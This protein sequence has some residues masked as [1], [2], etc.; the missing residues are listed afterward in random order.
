MKFWAELRRRHVIRIVLAYLIGAWLLIQVAVSIEAPLGLP[1]WFDTFVIVVTAIGFPIVAVLAWAFDITA[2]GVKRTPPATSEPAAPRAP[3]EPTPAAP[4]PP[5][6]SDAP[7]IAVLPF[8]DMSPEHDQEYFADGL[9][10][11]LLNVLAQIKALRVA[12]RTSSFYFKG[13][14][15]SLRTIADALGVSHVLEGSVRKAGEQ[16]R[17]T[18][19]LINAED[20]YHL[21]SETY[22]RTLD[23]IFTVQEE[24][25]RAVADALGVTLGLQEVARAPGGTGDVEAYDLYLRA[26]GLVRRAGPA[27]IER[28]EALIRDALKLDPDFALAWAT[29]AYVLYSTE[30]YI[31]SEA[32]R[33]LRGMDEA[34]ERALAIA[35]ELW[36]THWVR[37]LQLCKHQEWLKAEPAL[38]R[39]RELAPASEALPDTWY[40]AFLLYVGQAAGSLPVWEAA[41]RKDPLDV[42]TTSHG[43]HLALTCVGRPADAEA[44]YQRTR[45]VVGNRETS[46]F[47]WL[48]TLIARGD[49][50]SQ[51]KAQLRRAMV[52]EVVP[53][54]VLAELLDLWEQPAE[55]R[56][57]L[58]ATLDDPAYQDNLRQTKLGAFAGVIGDV[59]STFIA[60]RRA[61][62]D[63]QAT[64]LQVIWHPAFRDVRRDARFKELLR[65]VGLVD[66]WRETGNW[67]DF[68]RPIGE[69]DFECFG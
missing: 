2:E 55:V 28:A 63:L 21:W 30:I 33:A 10:E 26:Q 58:R 62:V 53:M 22:A 18:A 25:A 49:P 29:L 1:G 64:P 23:D 31:P 57:K 66:Y 60:W 67:G 24:V 46:E 5:T 9:S 45:D 52:H 3:P 50:A 43:L 13:K 16:L 12:A 35:P 32:E 42:S 39:A 38:R 41:I 27:E 69:D 47:F 37:G 59:D 11:E 8:V 7:S 19:Q 68:C 44:E 51:V 34:I 20:G 40:A 36:V 17:I 56:A 61:Y 15:E 4:P 65:D 54:P 48:L 6:A 14:G